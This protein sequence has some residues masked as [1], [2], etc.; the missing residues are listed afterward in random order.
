MQ[1]E[2]P[3]AAAER[4]TTFARAI[5]GGLAAHGELNRLPS[6]VSP[7]PCDH[8]DQTLPVTPPDAEN[9][10]T[11]PWYVDYSPYTMMYIGYVELM[12]S[13]SPQAVV[14]Q[15]RDYLSDLGWHSLEN[16]H[17]LPTPDEQDRLLIEAPDGGYGAQIIGMTTP[18]GR[19]RIAIYV[20]SP[21]LRHPEADEPPEAQ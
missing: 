14:I 17:E 16:N 21:C 6:E 9:P 4:V 13:T 8:I 1:V 15:L 2:H 7:Q 5:A 18:A 3:K 12:P 19:P 20:S 10:Y 11:D